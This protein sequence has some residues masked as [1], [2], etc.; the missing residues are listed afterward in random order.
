L[1]EALAFDTDVYLLPFTGVSAMERL[2]DAGGAVRVE[3]ASALVKAFDS[4][5]GTRGLNVG[6][7]FDPDAV[8]NVERAV[9]DIVEEQR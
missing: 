8:K 3:D 9:C 4:E 1:Y 7:V 5:Q 6:R 2:V